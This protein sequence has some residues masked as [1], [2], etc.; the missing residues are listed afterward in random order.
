LRS[1][2]MEASIDSSFWLNSSL[3][4]FDSSRSDFAEAINKS[5]F[6]Y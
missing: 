4:L 6:F 5:S 2:F 1:D 3:A